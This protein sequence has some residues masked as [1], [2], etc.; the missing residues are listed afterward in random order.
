MELKYLRGKTLW[1]QSSSCIPNMS[2]YAVRFAEE[3]FDSQKVTFSNTLHIL[4]DIDFTAGIGK[5]WYVCWIAARHIILQSMQGRVSTQGTEVIPWRA[6]STAWGSV[7]FLPGQPSTIL[8]SLFPLCMPTH[9]L[10]H[11][12]RYGVLCLSI[13][14][15]QLSPTLITRLRD[16]AQEVRF[17]PQLKP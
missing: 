13:P 7:C 5:F 9:H 10:L 15:D 1:F 11:W 2:Q 3:S 8:V 14:L 17:I 16:L 12:H 6:A 4:R